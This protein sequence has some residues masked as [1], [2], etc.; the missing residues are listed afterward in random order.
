MQVLDRI[1]FSTTEPPINC[2]WLKPV[3]D[4]FAAYI[5]DSYWKLL[6]LMNGHGTT[7]TDD[8]TPYEGGGGGGELGP[9]TVG[10]QEII[11][12]SIKLEDLNTE[13]TD[14]IDHTYVDENEALYIDGA[15]PIL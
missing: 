3:G 11:N 4:G 15:K 8:D 2:L 1:A 12:N 9:N 5:F 14:K 13:V 10:S 7:T 6:K